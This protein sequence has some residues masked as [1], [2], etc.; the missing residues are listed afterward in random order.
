MHKQNDKKQ[1]FVGW[2]SHDQ[3]HEELDL[4]A[5]VLHVVLQTLDCC[6]V[7]G[8]EGSSQVDL[9]ISATSKTEYTTPK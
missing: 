5:G 2:R 1:G 7:L 3:F 4:T 6:K 9:S 8:Q